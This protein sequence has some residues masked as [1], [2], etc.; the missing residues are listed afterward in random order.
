[1]NS[2]TAT[3]LL[4]GLE[5]GAI[6]SEE[7]VKGLLDGADRLKRLNVFVHLDPDHILSQARAIDKR[8]QSGDPVGPLAGVPVAIKDLLCVEGE[9]TTAG[10]GCSGR[11]GLPMMPRS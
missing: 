4:A 8:R 7:I 10:A 9:P 2:A 1:M 6:S 3:A 11:S 5:Q